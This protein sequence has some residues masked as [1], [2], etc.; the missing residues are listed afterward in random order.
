MLRDE[1]GR[2]ICR[3]KW[4]KLSSRDWVLVRNFHAV[5]GEGKRLCAPKKCF[6]SPYGYIFLLS[7]WF[8]T[9]KHP[10]LNWS[11]LS[12]S[13][14]FFLVLLCKPNPFTIINFCVSL[15]ANCICQFADARYLLD[16]GILLWVEQVL[17]FMSNIIYLFILYHSDVTIR[18]VPRCPLLYN[19]S[20]TS[21]RSNHS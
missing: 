4:E 21:K 16:Q 10:L 20:F 9:N 19:F 5:A 2:D 18:Y 3:V 17:I 6:S 13:L 12:L 14:S 1:W 15:F 7:L 11:S 8:C